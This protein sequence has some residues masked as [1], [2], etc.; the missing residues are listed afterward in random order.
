MVVNIEGIAGMVI[1]TGGRIT[2]IT[3]ETV[4]PIARTT[5]RTTRAVIDKTEE[6]RNDETSDSARQEHVAQG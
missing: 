6:E 5:V 4:F 1:V 2:Q 3:I